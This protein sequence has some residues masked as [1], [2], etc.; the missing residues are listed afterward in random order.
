LLL[1]ACAGH[2]GSNVSSQGDFG[3]KL[4]DTTI[5][6]NGIRPCS[7]SDETGVQ[8]DRSKPLVVLTH[9][10]LDSAARF[11]ALAEVFAFQDQQAVC[12]T[13]DDRDSLLKSSSEL[14][15]ALKQ[16][17]NQLNNKEITLIAHSQG[18]L[19]A[20]KAL[21]KQHASELWLNTQTRINLVTISA[22]FSGIEDAS[23]CGSKN[24]RLLTLGLVDAI[25]WMIS[26]D[27]WFEITNASSFIQMPGELLPQVGQY[28]KI[29]TDER[30][31]CRTPGSGNRCQESDY[32]FSLGEQHLQQASQHAPLKRIEVRAGHTEIVGDFQTPPHKL[33]SILQQQGIMNQTL[34]ERSEGLR[35]LLGRLY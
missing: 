22:P 26:G 6:I 12:F 24:L 16:L 35:I 29:D 21:T 33:I 15:Y 23:R 7:S 17:S 28:F 4:S 2:N 13:Y 19:I 32:V 30:D 14:S 31:S 11:K 27:K 8:I 34:P 9:G 20:R 18:G 3:K 1:T 10:C 25:C 5:H